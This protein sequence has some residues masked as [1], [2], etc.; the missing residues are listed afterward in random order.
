MLSGSFNDV[1]LRQ[2]QIAFRARI[3]WL[4]RAEND[5]RDLKNQA[6]FRREKYECIHFLE[7]LEQVTGHYFYDWDR[8]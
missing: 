6:Y 5:T 4:T 7:R 8:E 3:S 1:E 2:I